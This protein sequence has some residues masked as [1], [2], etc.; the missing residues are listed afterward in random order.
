M[1]FSLPSSRFFS[2][3]STF[4]SDC[5]LK[6][7]DDLSNLL[8]ESSRVLKDDQNDFLD[9]DLDGVRECPLL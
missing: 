2:L 1:S 6:L 5:D 7:E 3:S 9:D 4:F 8:A